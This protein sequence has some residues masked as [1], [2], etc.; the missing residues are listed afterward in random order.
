MPGSKIK[1]IKNTI[2]SNSGS[3]RTLCPMCAWWAKDAIMVQ[4]PNTDLYTCSECGY[5]TT[6]NSEPIHEEKIVAGNENTNQKPYVKGVMLNITK[7]IDSKSDNLYGSAS[8]AWN[9]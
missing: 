6:P 7:K 1:I 4:D 8:D 9:S 3:G 5:Q 2:H